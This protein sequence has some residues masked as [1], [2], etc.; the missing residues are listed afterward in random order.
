[1]CLVSVFLAPS[2]F[3]REMS[4]HLEVSGSL[5]RQF[6]ARKIFFKRTL[7]LLKKIC[8]AQAQCSPIGLASLKANS[9]KRIVMGFHQL[10]GLGSSASRG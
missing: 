8:S 10:S 6:D 5:P 1:V 2:V 7:D 3:A 9:G 4:L